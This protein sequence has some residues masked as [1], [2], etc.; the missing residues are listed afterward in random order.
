[1]S[2]LRIL[3]ADSD[4]NWRRD[5][6]LMASMTALE[7]WGVANGVTIVCTPPYKHNRSIECMMGVVLYLMN[8]LLCASFLSGL[9]WGRAFLHAIML[10]NRRGSRRSCLPALRGGAKSRFEAF[11]GFKA[12]VSLIVCPFGATAYVRL[13]D[14]KAA[15]LQSLAYQGLFIG[16]TKNGMACLS[17]Q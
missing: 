8:T 15:D 2:R 1:M 14:I 3:Y 10:I 7:R 5:E 11:Y 13:P 16:C 4:P 9:F 12:D 17:T 6:R